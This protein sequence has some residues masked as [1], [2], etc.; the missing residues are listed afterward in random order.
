[1]ASVISGAG[2]GLY[3]SSLN[4]L[5]SASGNA[6]LGAN[7]NAVYVN[8]Q[9]GNL[10]VQQQDEFLTSLGLDLGLARTY[11]SLGQLDGD[12]NDNWRINGHR[13]VHDLTGIVNAAGSTVQKTF[14]DGFT[15][16]YTFDAAS[17]TYLSTDGRGAHDTLSYNAGTNQWTWTDGT[18]GY[19][20]TYETDG[21]GNW[22][23]AQTADK[24]GLG[25]SFIYSNNLLSQVTDA[26]GQVTYL[27]WNGTNLTQIR[28]VSQGQT[29]ITTHYGYDAQNRL[30]TVQVDLTPDDASI[31]DGNTFNTTYTYDGI[32][33]R[34]ASIT[35]TDGTTVSFTYD[36][37]GRVKTYTD[38]TNQTTTLSYTQEVTVNAE[39][40]ALT[41]PPA[42]GSWTGP[43][44]IDVTVTGIEKFDPQVT[45]DENGNG[46]AVWV[47]QDGSIYNLYASRYD[48]GLATWS[49]PELLETDT[50]RA[51][52]PQIKLDAQGN[53]FV[54]WRQYGAAAGS[55]FVNRYDTVAQDW[56]GAQAIGN[57]PWSWVNAPQL[58]VNAQGD[59]MVAW[60]EDG[61]IHANRYL[62]GQ[63]WQ[64]PEVIQSGTTSIDP[65]V[66]L[67][68]SGNAMVGWVQSDGSNH[69]LF[70]KQF[71]ATTQGWGASTQI[72]TTAGSLRVFSSASYS[73]GPQWGTDTNGDRILVWMMWDSTTSQYTAY[74]MH[75]QDGEWQNP[76]PLGVGGSAP[77]IAVNDSG[78]AM[79]IWGQPGGLYASEYVPGSNWSPAVQ[80]PSGLSNNYQV[81]ID[82]Q[83]NATVIWTAGS[84]DTV[85]VRRYSTV[86]GWGGIER[87]ERLYNWNPTE[88]PQLHMTDSGAISVAW[89]Q[90]D[91]A[92]NDYRVFV[93]RYEASGGG[94]AYYTVQTADSWANMA[95]TVYNDPSPDAAQAL[96]DYFA[97]QNPPVT[98][99][100]AGDQL[101]MPGALTYTRQ[102]AGGNNQTDV[103]DPLGHTSTYLYDI[104]GRLQEVLSP[105]VNGSNLSTFY[106]Y[107]AQDNIT[108]ITDGNGNN[109]NFNYQPDGT[110]ANQQDAMGNRV[111]YTYNNA[112]QLLNTIV[113]L[114]P[115]TD[116][117]GPDMASQPVVSRNVYDSEGHLRFSV[118]ADG[119][120]SEKQ[121]NIAGEL[122]TAMTYTG[123]VYDVSALLITDTL[124]EAQLQS[125]TTTQD[126][127]KTQRVDMS[128]DFRG[129]LASTTTYS[130]VDATGSGVINGQESLSLFIYDQH[131]RLIETIDPRGSQTTNP[132]DYK[133]QTNYD[134]LG[135]ITN[136]YVYDE[137]GNLITS[138]YVTGRTSITAYDDAN[139]TVSTTIANGFATTAV[140]DARGLLTSQTQTAPDA[141]PLGTTTYH[142]DADGK[143]RYTDNALGHRVH[144]I[145]D[146]ADR[147]VGTVDALGALT[148]I[149]YDD[150]S[151]VF[152]TKAYANTL[153][154]GQLT[155][156]NTDV[157]PGVASNVSIDAVR[158]V[159]DLTA[160]RQAFTLYDRANRPVISIVPHDTDVTQGYVTQT[161]YDGANRVT[162]VIAYANAVS[163]VGLNSNSI[164]D[165]IVLTPNATDDRHVRTF[166][167]NDGLVQGTVDGEGYISKNNYNGAGQLTQTVSYAQADIGNFTVDNWNQIQ[168]RLNPADTNNKTSF[169][170][171]NARGQVTGTLSSNNILSTTDYDLAGNVIESKTYSTII[172][173]NGV[174]SLSAITPSSVGMQWSSNSYD[175]QN[176]LTSTSTNVSN[177]GTTNATITTTEFNYDVVGNVTETRLGVGTADVR[178][179]S[180]QYDAAG[181]VTQELSARGN[182]AL[183]ALSNPTQ[184]DIDTL[185]NQ[186]AVKHTYNAIG[187]RV[188]SSGANGQQSW[189]YYDDAGHLKAT[190]TAADNERDG[191]INKG[192]VT[193]SNYN[194]FDQVVD[195]TTFANRLDTSTLTGGNYQDIDTVIQGLIVSDTNA[196]TSNINYTLRGAVSEAINGNGYR[197]QSTY[198]A[199]GE[200]VLTRSEDTPSATAGNLLLNSTNSIGN[201]TTYDR[202]G[203][204]TAS[205]QDI[206]GLNRQTRSTTDAFGRTTAVYINSVLQQSFNY[207][208]DGIGRQVTTTS[209]AMGYNTVTTYDA[210]GRTLSTQDKNGQVYTTTHN[211]ENQ[212][213]TITTPEGITTSTQSNAHGETVVI[214]DGNNVQT[215][216]VY[217]K[218]GNVSNTIFD[219]GGLNLTR[220]NTFDESGRTI[221]TR[222]A[223]G[224]P[225]LYQYDAQ[226]RVISQTLDPKNYTDEN[227]VAQNN[228]SG[229]N[230]VTS[231]QYTAKGQ[232]QFTTDA[233]GTITE[234]RFDK[235]GQVTDV[236][237]DASPA[238][239]N[240]QTHYDYNSL[241]QTLTVTEGFNTADSRTTEYRYDDLGRRTHTIVD[242]GFLDITTEYK[243]DMNDNVVAVIDANNNIT[244]FIFDA[245]QR[246]THVVDAENG[247]TVTD[248]DKNGNVLK[249]HRYA[250]RVTIS[251]T[252]DAY[253]LTANDLTLNTSVNDNITR[254]AYDKDNRLTYTVDTLGG[255][256]KST[257]D[258]N[259]NII[260]Q[261]RY[262][263]AIS[264]STIDAAVD[265][266]ATINTLVVNNTATNQTTHFYYDAANRQT[267]SLSVFENAGVL[268]AYVSEHAFD[269]NGN[270][271]ATLQYAD[272]INVSVLTTPNQPNESEV[273]AAIFTLSTQNARGTLNVFDAANRLRFSV[274]AL[275]YVTELQTDANGQTTQSTA[276]A[277]QLNGAAILIA[278]G[279]DPTGLSEA[280]IRAL[281]PTVLT[282]T[283]LSAGLV[284]DTQKD[285]TNIFH[286]DAAGRMDYSDDAL[287]QREYYGYDAVGNQVWMT[288]KMGSTAQDVNFTWTYV[289]DKANRLAQ[290]I[291]PAVNVTRLNQAS[292][293]VAS[294]SN[295]AIITNIT[296]DSLGNVKT[297]T[298]AFGSADASTMTY[299]YDA[300]NRVQRA[301]DGNGYVTDTTYTSLGQ[302]ESTTNYMNA[303]IT[304]LDN[305][306]ADTDLISG[307]RQ[308]VF[309]YDA[310]GRTRTK[311]DASINGQP[312]VVTQYEYNRF[313]NVTDKT[314]GFG[315]TSA[316]TTH[317][318][319]DQLG[320]TQSE[321]TAYGQTESSTLAYGYN[322]FNDQTTIIDPRAIELTETDTT[323]AQ[324]ERQRLGYTALVSGLNNADKAAIVAAYTSTQAFDEVGRKLNAFDPLGAG[325][326]TQYDAFGNIVKTTDANASDGYFYYDQLNRLSIQIDPMGYV[327]E[328]KY[329]KVGNVTETIQYTNQ[330]VGTF[331][332]NSIVEFFDATPGTPPPVYLI[333]NATKDQHTYAAHDAL[334]RTTTITDAEGYSETFGY[335]A[336]GNT[337]ARTD[338][339]NNTF[340]YAF[341]KNN[342]QTD[343][344]LPV[345]RD[346]GVGVQIQVVNQT[347]YDALGNKTKTIEAVGLP[348]TR[349]TTF[350][351]DKDNQL[352]EK[353]LPQ[354][355]GSQSVS[356]V[357]GS[358]NVYQ[359][360]NFNVDMAWYAGVS[361]R[362]TSATLSWSKIEGYGNG[363]IKIVW[364]GE[365]PQYMPNGSSLNPLYGGPQI[366][367]V[368]AN[369]TSLTDIYGGVWLLEDGIHPMS[370][371]IYKETATGYIKIVEIAGVYNEPNSWG[372]VI[373]DSAIGPNMFSYTPANSSATSVVMRYWP[374]SNVNNITEITFAKQATNLIGGMFPANLSGDYAYEAEVYDNASELLNRVSGTFNGNTSATTISAQSTL[375][376]QLVTPRTYT[377]Y[378]IHANLITEIDAEGYVTH[379]YYDSNNRRIASIN[380]ERY[381]TT[382]TYNS[383][384]DVIA[385]RTYADAINVS[386]NLD[387]LPAV[388]SL[389]G[390][391]INNYREEQYSYDVNHRLVRTTTQPVQLY[392]RTSGLR[393]AAITTDTLYDANGNTVKTID[394]NGNATYYFYDKKGNHI[395]QVDAAGFL[396]SL[397]Y[398]GNGNITQQTQ[399]ASALTTSVFSS[400]NQNS[401]VNDLI[402]DVTAITN[403]DDRTSMFG[404][405]KV[406][407]RVSETQV[408]IQFSSLSTNVTTEG[409]LLTQTPSNITTTYQYDGLGNI[410]AVIQPSSDNIGTTQM[411]Y[412]YDA[413][414]RR[415]QEQSQAYQDN[416]NQ[417][418]RL[419]RDIIYDGV[420]NIV[421]EINRGTNDLV[422]TD[423]QII[424]HQ[425]DAYGNVIQSTDAEGFTTTYYY[426]LNANVS[427]SHK[428][429][430]NPDG[431]R[432]ATDTFYNYDKLNQQTSTTD[433]KNFTYF[434]T[435][436]A[437]GEIDS[438]GLN[439]LAQEFN[440]Y[441]ALGNLVKTNKDGGVYKAYLYDAS[442]N[443]TAEIQS[444]IVD[445]NL[446]TLNIQQIAALDQTTLKR[447]ESEYDV[448]NQLISTYETPMLIQQDNV[449]IEKTWVSVLGDPFV[450]G[451]LKLYKGGNVNFSA[452]SGISGV[453]A[454]WT[455]P[456]ISGL[457]SGLARVEWEVSTG[458][459]ILSAAFGTSNVYDSN[460][461][462]VSTNILESETLA[463]VINVGTT[464]LGGSISP[465]GEYK[466][467]IIKQS[468]LYGDILVVE[469]IGIYNDWNFPTPID[470]STPDK[471][472]FTGL[473]A[474]ADTM[475]LWL[476]PS[477]GIKGVSVPVYKQVAAGTPIDGWFTFDWSSYADGNYNY[478]YKVKDSGGVELDYIK[479][480]LTLG[481]N[482]TINSQ[483]QEQL[484]P[485][486]TPII[487]SNTIVRSQTYNAFGEVISETDGRGHELVTRDTEWATTERV[488]LGYAA[489]V[490]SLTETD[491]Q[492]LLNIYTT[493]M[494]YD[495]RGNLIQKQSPET[496]VTLADGSNGPRIRPTTNYYYDAIGRAIAETD[497][498]DNITTQ[499][500][501]EAGLLKGEYNFKAGYAADY[502]KRSYEYDVFGN[503][504][505]MRDQLNVLTQY[506]YDNKNQLTRIDHETDASFGNVARYETFEYDEMGNRIRHTNLKGNVSTTAYDDIGRVKTYS[507]YARIDTRYQYQYN[508][509]TG[510]MKVT[511]QYADGRS[512]EENKNYFGVL[513]SKV[514]MGNHVYNY[515]YNQAGW[516]THQDST[517]GQ[518]I[519][520]T[521]YQN[522]RQKEIID[523][524][525][526]SK[527]KYEYDVN[528]NRI[529]E[530]Y[531][532]AS[533]IAGQVFYQWSN[534]VYDELNRVTQIND[535]KYNLRYEYDANGN[536]IHTYARYH[537]GLNANVQFQDYWYQYDGMNR[538][539][540]T[541]GTYSGLVVDGN[542]APILDSNGDYQWSRGATE[543]VSAGSTGY[544][545]AYNNASQRTNANNERYEY[546]SAN[547]LTKTFI[548]GSDNVERLRAQRTYD[549]LGN[550]DHYYEY[551]TSG[552]ETRHLQYQY[553][554]DGKTTSQNDILAGNTVNY[555]Y[556]AAGNLWYTS[557]PQQ[558][559]NIYTTYYYDYWDTAKQK[560]IKIQG[561]VTAYTPADEWKP[562]FSNFTYDVNGHLTKVSD[563][564]D[565]RHLSYKLDQQGKILQRN[566]IKN[567]ASARTQYYYYL[568]GHGVGDSGGFG[569]SNTDYAT[570]LAN[571]EEEVS[572]AAVSSADFDYNYL[573]INDSYPATT[574][575]TYTVQ[576]DGES[577]QSIALAVWGDSSL[578]YMIADANGLDGT[579]LVANQNLVIPNAVTN[580]HN[581]ATTFKVYNP[582]E[583]LGN[584]S[585]TLPSAPLPP[586]PPANG[587]SQIAM[588]IMIVVIVVVS[589]Y[590]AGAATQALVAAGYAATSAAVIVASAAI[591]AAVGSIAGQLVGMELGIVNEFSW[592]QVGVA[593]VTAALTAGVGEYLNAGALQGGTTGA[594]ASRAI[595]TNISVQGLNILLGEQEKF[596]WRSVAVSGI[597]AAVTAKGEVKPKPNTASKIPP[598]TPSPTMDT[599]FVNNLSKGALTEVVKTLVYKDH[600]PQWASVA[601]NAI[602]VTIGNELNQQRAM[603]AHAA[604]QKSE[605][606]RPAFGIST[607]NNTWVSESLYDT[608]QALMNIMPLSGEVNTIDPA[609]LSHIGG[610]GQPVYNSWSEDIANKLSELNGYAADTLNNPYLDPKIRQNIMQSRYEQASEYVGQ[611]QGDEQRLYANALLSNFAQSYYGDVYNDEYYSNPRNAGVADQSQYSNA[612]W[613]PE[614]ATPVSLEL[615]SNGK[616]IITS[617][618]SAE[619]SVVE[620]G[621]ASF[622]NME[623]SERSFV[624]KPLAD[625]KEKHLASLRKVTDWQIESGAS[626]IAQFGVWSAYAISDLLIPT[627]PIDFLPAEKLAGPAY[628]LLKSVDTS[629]L[630]R[631]SRN[632][633]MLDRL[634]LDGVPNTEIVAG[635][636]PV[637]N[638]GYPAAGRIDNCVN[639][640]I[641]TDRTFA[642]YPTSAL[643]Q[644]DPRGVPISEIPKGLGIEG[645]FTKVKSLDDVISTFGEFGAGSRG[646]VFG[647]RGLGQ[648][649]HVFNTVVD[650]RG[651]VKFWD[652]QSMSRPTLE[653]QGYKNFWWIRSEK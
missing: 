127:T 612:S 534:V 562:G 96:Q 163:I 397:Q 622:G 403:L 636:A 378:D 286:Y 597:A 29:S 337:I 272:A 605:M 138:S 161:F 149:L 283:T 572:S 36:A 610:T 206:D 103:T 338:K 556:D 75:Y 69:H 455:L 215:Q 423:D 287:Q 238:G 380:A 393:T 57:G 174:D 535:P 284:S 384:D 235:A 345:T 281:I 54:V 3:N 72:E 9:S 419:T 294:I 533:P 301:I 279:I 214:T 477:G 186:W 309:T 420:G 401:L 618:L 642:G 331:N 588:V 587:C 188:Q 409:R 300:L 396:T 511:T 438:K 198:N 348:E 244:R 336:R 129:N 621:N 2:L 99:L 175:A 652:G 395:A 27:D 457:G 644:F 360:I 190:I 137:A 201:Q 394:G 74:A 320:R 21:A 442:G 104:E 92:W 473:P 551:N 513:Q 543:S 553:D 639:C 91:Q 266:T 50:A 349:T 182:E 452:G 15:A 600:K 56:S 33:N 285:Q 633:G 106:N 323:W 176:R 32:S 526:D 471:I 52:N 611:I 118:S 55:V 306:V 194:S 375:Q 645:N 615:G 582:G 382:Y 585:P 538:F 256:S 451:D 485:V 358:I 164:P 619:G 532:Q 78:R 58:A 133:T 379:Y 168:T 432:P 84:D 192:D 520:Y 515:D 291:T 132:N 504:V 465:G 146:E 151:N 474:E 155:L 606:E 180:T 547:L 98:T 433:A 602:G 561:A 111:E 261:T 128:Y 359:P 510:G 130:Q 412:T 445:A 469:F 608:D 141:T 415:I 557:N 227:G 429:R 418:V 245:N 142:Y 362:S 44:A 616:H 648:V 594:T 139:N 249:T 567:A 224:T 552:T 173:Y 517:A 435:Y 296:Y 525:V 624:I 119:R 399:Y 371:E 5:G 240:L 59:A 389:I 325:T 45:F 351:Y 76:Q 368:N 229:L 251:A 85:Y 444:A 649:G 181:R 620:M 563:E 200:S 302:V 357:A 81:A 482:P 571:R 352:V 406:N 443:A 241:G 136:S 641:A 407:Q 542:G 350:I 105:A 197:A 383:A 625:L 369:S 607:N 466:V 446:Q 153:T 82:G 647:D 437:Y 73:Y 144:S 166:Y 61:A 558:G 565:N 101:V 210:F 590:T 297:R 16:T 430:L 540:V 464:H 270:I 436:N 490:D 505:E 140:F 366:F 152:S 537:D 298:Q 586:P 346:N 388:T 109:T 390:F 213:V 373:S 531:T 400:L 26:S 324:A 233:N 536:R 599:K 459:D 48:V 234:T 225:R 292:P 310:L 41:T 11:N 426:D 93:N 232:V 650:Q 385:S 593:A 631:G 19:S 365:W 18:V 386:V 564:A 632:G 102:V 112:N 71:N 402:T 592:K 191:I 372:A 172:N 10:V 89:V 4:I 635:T 313:G 492:A 460:G 275:G 500:F 425:Y 514:D 496:N 53:V 221:L 6:Q 80:V 609:L 507:S 410:N 463:T 12:N 456:I 268:N 299:Q 487:V 499:A 131:G 147:L 7:G 330:V 527:T 381:L 355:Q 318:V 377:N 265:R 398:D 157:A 207:S 220:S 280:Q 405:D 223:N 222:D 47:Q 333:R 454:N 170:F 39:L 24:D 629:P 77:Q 589:I 549:A 162:D 494:S 62:A 458:K 154:A 273:R 335:D 202:R 160:D 555:I 195:S 252:A 205:Y 566:E 495:K 288:N 8:S 150:A 143:L 316:Q 326:Q 254:Y 481:A 576:Y 23:L 528:G 501:N 126:K 376:A 211:D 178:T 193:L 374:T 356:S 212:T 596:D 311:T 319:Y 574:P 604:R 171:Y 439:G 189:Y 95:S 51:L 651:T 431:M 179:L 158:P 67:D 231:T 307:D 196:S 408:G 363:Q 122:I 404:Y 276:Y 428:A 117:D 568:N 627:T 187:Q 185:W 583:L 169:I 327:T 70:A 646:V 548:T 544:A 573:P 304:V 228:T 79:A 308:T 530:G 503:K 289:Y 613:L 623:V 255:V 483:L 226:N 628:K 217:D 253:T 100:T 370:F 97:A 484:Q 65:L 236:I 453:S 123:N 246:Q 468:D 209:D 434:S 342:Q 422:T 472:Q 35:H 524:G 125:W 506:Q 603:N 529:F 110:L 554:G 148:E 416:T 282:E 37:S 295:E 559:A 421:Q 114:T 230:L 322:A 461:N 387:T 315:T 312:G 577:L 546:N 329:G 479:G 476:W 467:R 167:S 237:V 293:P 263:T 522:G 470:V 269:T 40:A 86:D 480:D 508:N 259:S 448:R 267:L 545:V 653:G 516:L 247:I 43:V 257:Y 208:T 643:P 341:D 344:Y 427:V 364:N 328:S 518:N 17:N 113:Y 135:R 278:A 411:D 108:S 449:T 31:I 498:N 46:Y 391:D 354:V 414:G 317:I 630:L 303:V 165:D 63:A 177:T 539:V 42:T 60:Y 475:E 509:V 512:N 361:G 20:E 277:N 417:T 216:Y 334:N 462:V 120:V 260:T 626:G 591:G 87:V 560:Q 575:G 242:P 570:L 218:D 239:L 264:T 199:F 22:R 491:K 30:E 550:V 584:T 159:L 638:P 134:G 38:G 124:T 183:A 634:F 519:D 486:N 83:G 332:E 578:W 424:N 28:V 440:E 489:L 392:D 314:Q 121:Y 523:Y 49:A 502:G 115:D 219:Q 617:Y 595:I 640:A 107:D 204:A 339:N 1:M 14:G 353:V 290:E 478:E 579:P 367:Y 68:D 258:N 184:T 248:Y 64:A 13:R 497:A 94:A 34:I 413:L 493:Q 601:A 340:N 637:T 88:S 441:D 25:H 243:Y 305:P 274:D 321:T 614:G 598:Q 203:V 250:Q 262:A 569:T 66:Y 347:V 521:Y 90:G 580:V 271:I 541:K 450:G 145:Y 343:E 156:L 581:N 488:R 116:G 447:T